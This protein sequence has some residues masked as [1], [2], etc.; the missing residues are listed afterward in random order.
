M[1]IYEFSELLS[2]AWGQSM[3]IKNITSGFKVMGVYRYPVDRN[4]VQVSGH[5]PTFIDPNLW[6]KNQVWLTFP[7]IVQLI[8]ATGKKQE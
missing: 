4:A 3:I 6:Q 5:K 7:C 2:E 1:S 8:P